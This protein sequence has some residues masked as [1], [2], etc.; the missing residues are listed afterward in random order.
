[1]FS[2]HIFAYKSVFGV[3]FLLGVIFVVVSIKRSKKLDFSFDERVELDEN[4]LSDDQRQIKN[5]FGCPIEIRHQEGVEGDLA[6]WVYPKDIV[7]F[8][9]N[10]TLRKKVK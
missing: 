8:N 2:N 7:I 6:Y 1:M 5:K 4:K 10:G 3:L 9:E